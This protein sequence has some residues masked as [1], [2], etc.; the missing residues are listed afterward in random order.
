M[1]TYTS[2]IT[3]SMLLFLVGNSYHA[4]A[5]SYFQ[6]HAVV[7]QGLALPQLQQDTPIPHRGSGR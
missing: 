1:S 5:Q 2:V 3:A 6:R 4:S 7:V